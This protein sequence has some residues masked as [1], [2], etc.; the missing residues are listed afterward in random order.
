MGS[1]RLVLADDHA[2]FRRGL[3]DLLERQAGWQVVA[4][5]VNGQ[6]AVEK[7]LKTEPD[8]AILDF[9]MPLVD[10]LEVARQIAKRGVK[11]RI[12]ILTM[13]ESDTLVHEMLDAG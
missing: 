2:I 7:V 6:E 9:Q 11:T 8:V 13:H 3:R 10:G 4:E 1:L 5:A 12:L